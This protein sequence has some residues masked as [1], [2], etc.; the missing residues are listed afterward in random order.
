MKKNKK[1]ILGLLIGIPLFL[2]T[3][4]AFQPSQSQVLSAANSHT[5]KTTITSVQTNTVPTLKL[6]VAPTLTPRPT[7][8]PLPTAKPTIYIVPTKPYVAP[9][10][11]PATTQSISGLSNNNYYQNVNGN[12][13]HA[14]AH[15]T[16]NSV[17]AGATA[18]CG[19]GTYSFSQHHSG[20]CS[21]HG[22]VAEWL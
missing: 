12:E 22:G 18:K 17:P 10:T 4:S 8:T 15:S 11:P 16:D 21:H 1:I 14:P 2:G 3:I 5:P 13:V 6:T 9:T 20:T 19:D 7:V